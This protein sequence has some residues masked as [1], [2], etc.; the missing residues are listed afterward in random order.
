MLEVAS[1][2]FNYLLEIL[3][4]G[5]TIEVGRAHFETET[6]RFTILD[7][8]VSEFSFQNKYMVFSLLLTQWNQTTSK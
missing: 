4:Q 2:H 3:L 8:P 1:F 6:T 5:K 7:A